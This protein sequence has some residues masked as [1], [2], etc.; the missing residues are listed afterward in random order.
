MA[1]QN[2][3][4]I[5]LVSSVKNPQAL[6]AHCSSVEGGGIPGGERDSGGLCQSVVD[7]DS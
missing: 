5:P 2:T 7:S 3:L 6:T 4:Q 1:L